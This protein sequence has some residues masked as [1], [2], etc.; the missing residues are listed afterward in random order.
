MK[1]TAFAN[2]LLD[3]PGQRPPWMRWLET[4]PEPLRIA[5]RRARAS[6]L[7]AQIPMG[8]LMTAVFAIGRNLGAFK[9]APWAGACIASAALIFIFWPLPLW[10]L[11]RAATRSAAVT[12]GRMRRQ[13]RA[14][15]LFSY[16]MAVL[17]TTVTVAISGLAI[18]GSLLAYLR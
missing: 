7:L 1:L 10:R 8:L 3:R 15:A 13:I 12:T 9:A 11:G 2:W 4:A 14:Y 16:V 18:V 5:E 6:F 17:M